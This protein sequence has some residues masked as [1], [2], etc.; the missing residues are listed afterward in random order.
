[1][2]TKTVTIS[3][4]AFEDLIRIKENFEVVM[5]SLELMENEEF[6]VSYRKAKKELKNRDFVDWDE[7]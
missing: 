2:A 5:E 4:D 1:M 3:Q 6:M 7:L